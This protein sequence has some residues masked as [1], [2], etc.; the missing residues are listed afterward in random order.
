MMEPNLQLA[1]VPKKQLWTG[2]ILSGLAVAFLIFDVVIHIMSPPV[3]VQGFT[4]LGYSPSLARPLG[5]IELACLILYL[6]PRTSVLGAVLL[7]GYLGGAVA[8]NLRVAAPLLS[9]TLFP[10]YVAL[11]LWGGLVLRNDRLRT[12][13]P[14]QE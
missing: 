3:V 9:N 13:F 8:T 2:R 10:I 12:V 1:P 7:T 6:I 5:I 11:F 4:D 14:L